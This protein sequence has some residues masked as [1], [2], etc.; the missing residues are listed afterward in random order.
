VATLVGGN[1]TLS[2]VVSG[3][4]VVL[5]NPVSGSYDTR[6][7]GSGKLVSVSGL[8]LLGADAGNYVLASTSASAAI[9]TINAATLTAGLTG[10]AS[11][12]YDGTTVATLVGGNYTLSG[13]VSGDAVVL[14]NPASG[15]YDTK[16]AGTGKTVNVSGLGL[17]GADAGNYVL[18]S[19]GASAAIGT[20]NAATL[21]AGLTGSV[22]K[23]Y[24]GTIAA[25]LSSANYTLSGVV[26]GDAVALN[27]PASG[28]YDTKNA[29]SGKLVSVSGLGLSGA[30]AGNY[31][32][33]STNA[34]GAIGTIN[35]AMLSAGLTGNVSKTY[36]GT[37][38][39]TLASTNYALSGAVAGDSV[40]LNN[41][42]SG[43]Y[44]TKNAGSGKLVSVSGL[45]LS[46]ADAGN[47]VLASTDAAAAIGT[48]I[49]TGPQVDNGILADLIQTPDRLGESGSSAPADTG[50]AAMM[51]A[52]G[53][54]GPG[55]AGQGSEPSVPSDAV[56]NSVGQ[57][58]SREPG[59]VPSRINILIGGL[60][61]QFVPG[62][63]A[64]TQRGVPPADWDY[65][66]WGNE[67][68]WQ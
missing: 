25:T 50:G 56:A 22:S 68:F 33:A 12:T 13:T 20:I 36:D 32:L 41:P 6:N 65:S 1:Y 62:P 49:S 52:M 14:N 38:A 10:N 37:T 11:K 7:A 5:N 39:A 60:L 16:N 9:G 48:I 47:Y 17:S 40:A 54:G 59:S 67:A 61:R 21:N 66:S 46:G 42:A 31:V 45:G 55:P 51:G 8:A 19:T 35:A 15:S 3:D 23:T 44:D 4:G 24:D 29:G 26:S 58:L 34:S 64:Y 57:S 43:S 63:G 30:D 2:G 18:A 53:M 27:D 28:S